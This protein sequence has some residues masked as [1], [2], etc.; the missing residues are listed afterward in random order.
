M[1]YRQKKQQVERRIR[2]VKRMFGCIIATIIVAVCAF[3]AFYPPKTWKYYLN[4]PDLGARGYGEARIHFLDVGQGDSVLIELP[5]GKVALIDGGNGSQDAANAVL[6]HLNGLHID[7]IDYLVVTHA[8][9]DH[10]G[11]LDLVLEYKTVLNAYL[12]AVSVEEMGTEYAEFYAAL[13]KEEGCARVYSSISVS[14]SNTNGLFPYTFQFLYPYTIDAKEEGLEE[15]A[16]KDSNSLSSVL[17]F[18]Y[19]GIS[20]LLTGDAPAATEEKLVWADGKGFLQPYGVDLRSTEILKVAHH[21]S[22]GSTSLAFLQYL[23]AKTAVI[24]CGRNNSYGHPNDEVLQNLEAV[25]ATAY[26]TDELGT[27]VVSIQ[28]SGSYNVLIPS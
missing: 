19:K 2:I 12:P 10:C 8:D 9:A 5:D 20:A 11:S 24:S 18:D 15:N 6:R 4:M 17:W 26:R 23:R 13:L 25:G 21:G 7:T 22:S 14:L 28:P 3:S 27:V 16:K 1:G